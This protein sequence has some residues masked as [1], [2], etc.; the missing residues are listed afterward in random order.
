MPRYY[1]A[2]RVGDDRIADP[3]GRTLPDP[4]AAWEVA[5]RLI[6]ELLRESG[7]QSRLL[8][9]SLEVTDANGEIVFEMPFAEALHEPDPPQT[10]H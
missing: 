6:R 2:T 9:A 8:A 7:P 4:D 3:D 5:R 1:F 10:R